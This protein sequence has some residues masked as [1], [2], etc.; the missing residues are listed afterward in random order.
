MT[1]KQIERIKKKIKSYRAMLSAEKRK[2]GGYFDNR[3]LRYMLPE[4]YLKI[5]DYKGGLNYYRWFAREFPDDIGFPEFNLYWAL[6]LFKNN[7]ME[8]AIAKTYKTAFSNTYLIDLICSKEV[9]SIDKSET[10]GFESLGYAKEVV[11]D[12]VKLLTDDFIIWLNSL[13]KTEDY[14]SN[15]NKFISIQKLIKD[16]PVGKLRSKLIDESGKLEKSLTKE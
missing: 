16:E 10:I 2:F 9:K 6:T 3:S 11:D 1:D 5:M 7:K 14:K 12:C 13:I 15:L 8:E 4:F